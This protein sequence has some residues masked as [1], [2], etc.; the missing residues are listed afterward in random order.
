MGKNNVL[1]QLADRLR[2]G[3]TAGS[4]DSNC[5][6]V[7]SE[8]RLT[9]I[10]EQ[11]GRSTVCRGM[12]DGEYHGVLQQA[13]GI[14]IHDWYNAIL[15]NDEIGAN[16]T[17][18]FDVWVKKG[19]QYCKYCRSIQPEFNL[20]LNGNRQMVNYGGQLACDRC[21]DS[22]RFQTSATIRTWLEDWYIEN[23]KMVLDDSWHTGDMRLGIG[24]CDEQ[25]YTFFPLSLVGS[26]IRKLFNYRCAYCG[27]DFRNPAKT[28]IDW[29][30]DHAMARKKG[31]HNVPENIVLACKGCNSAKGTK[32]INEFYVYR[33][34][35]GL[36]VPSS[37]ETVAREVEARYHDVYDQLTRDDILRIKQ[38]LLKLFPRVEVGS[39][40]RYHP[41]NFEMGR[42]K[43]GSLCPTPGS[44][45][46][47]VKVYD[48]SRCSVQKQGGDKLY[49]VC[50]RSLKKV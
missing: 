32:T 2:S 24:E 39:I 30:F 47:V 25:L 37:L 43:E 4:L 10:T 36:P 7:P 48:R 34:A 20:V 27:A 45:V 23:A 15:P 13:F 14:D 35:K 16:D 38:P 41:I 1:W 49:S 19:W 5:L 9:S 12:S 11:I 28:R 22:Y 21:I 6:L 18:H 17:A 3:P 33:R 44:L 40:Y 42:A 29:E 46:T 8:I 31:G 26:I 50:T